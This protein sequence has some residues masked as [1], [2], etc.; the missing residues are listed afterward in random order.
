MI[1]KRSFYFIPI[2]FFA[3]LGLFTS[4][5]HYHSE[6]LE[7]LDHAEEAHIIQNESFCPICT[8]VVNA[9][10]PEPLS[11][12]AYIAFFEILDLPSIIQLPNQTSFF[13]SGRAPPL[14]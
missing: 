12:Q 14:V 11:F 10:I 3:V 13:F 7:C 2:A 4:L 6:G 9:G 1:N 8:L 5:V